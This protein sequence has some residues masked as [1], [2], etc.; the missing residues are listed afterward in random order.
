M[1]QELELNASTV[2]ILVVVLVLLALALR[3]AVRTWT[4]K[5][6]C[7]DDDGCECKERSKHEDRD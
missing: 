3:V 1:I 6:G 5:R 7:H 4:G 2:I